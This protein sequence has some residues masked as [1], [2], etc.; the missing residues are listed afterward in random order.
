MILNREM[1]VTDFNFEESLNTWHNAFIVELLKWF[2]K[3]KA[4]QERKLLSFTRPFKI[5]LVWSIRNK[6]NIKLF[7]FDIIVLLI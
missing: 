7:Y 6:K 2:E 3:I 1:K 5:K 4:M